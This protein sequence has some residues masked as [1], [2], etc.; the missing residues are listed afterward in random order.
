MSNLSL[1][2]PHT[3]S[4]EEALGRIKQLISTLKEEQKGNISD[5]QENWEGNKGSFSINA[6][7]F[8][9]SGSIEV[10]DNSADIEADLP[11]AVSFFKGAI[12]SMISERA[13]KLLA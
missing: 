6:K 3:L 9:F 2:I 4:K 10:K 13:K 7:G 1:S 5:V 11:M 8:A 12:S